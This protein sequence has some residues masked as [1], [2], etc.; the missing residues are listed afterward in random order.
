MKDTR[1]AKRY[2][3]ALF[4]VA[5]RDEIMDAVGQDI[6][7][8]ERMLREMP[9][10]ASLIAH[11]LVTEERKQK[12]LADVL[13]DRITAVSLNFLKLLVRKRR[14]DIL[15]AVLD[16]FHTLLSD[17]LGIVGAT[18]RTAVAMTADQTSR[19][20]AG[21]EK[22]TGKRVTLS[23]EIDPSVLG[24]VV[25][26]IGDDIIDGSVRGQLQRLERHLLGTK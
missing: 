13:G 23:A 1:V 11:P 5:L 25:V 2:A 8:I 17:H 21:L 24:G 26:R 3:A 19:L 12:M 20:A 9:S 18:V 14:A 6:A 4:E 10:L 16:E 22:L 15:D 7:V